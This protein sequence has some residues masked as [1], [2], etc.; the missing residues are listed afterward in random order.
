MTYPTDHLV[1][2]QSDGTVV[3]FTAGG[4][5]VRQMMPD[6]T[7]YSAFDVDGRAHYV[8][9]PPVNGQPA[10]NAHIVYQGGYTIFRYDDRSVLTFDSHSQAVVSLQLPDSTVYS[11]YGPDKR[12]HQVYTPAHDG[13]PATTATITYNNDGTTTYTYTD[14]T[15]ITYDPNNNILTE[16]RPD[17]TTYTNFDT[18]KRPHQIHT[19][20][21]DGKPATTATITYNNDGTT[22]YT[23]TDHTTITYDPNNNIL[24]EQRPDG[25]T[26]TNFDTDK[27]PHQVYTPAHDGKPATTATITYNNDG[28]TTYT[29]TDHTTITYDPN[30]NILTEQRPDGTTYTNFDTDKRPHQ[31]YTPA[32]DGKPATTATIT[33]NNDG[34]TTY[35][36]TDHTT[37]TYDPNNNILTEQ[38]PDG[39]VISFEAGKP[40]SGVNTQTNETVQITPAEGGGTVW[41]YSGGTVVWRDPNGRVTKMA[42]GGWTFTQFDGDSRPIYG[43]NGQQ[44]VSIQYGVNGS[45]T[46]WTYTDNNGKPGITV[47]TNS[48]GVP[49]TQ[50]NPDGSSFEF[51]VEIPKLGEAIKTVARE[52]DTINIMISGIKRQ[53]EALSMDWKSPAGTN[54]AQVVA[55]V[56]KLAVTAHLILSDA[57]TKMVHSYENYV[58]ADATNARNFFNDAN[59]PLSINEFNRPLNINEFNEPLNI[60]RPQ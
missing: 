16:Q 7:T 4:A 24:T 22:T 38:G 41:T 44:S 33:Y 37:I 3:E 20:A 57:V 14:H 15:T 46:K 10:M 60:K 17:G 40:K 53:F 26:Y 55:D 6:G 36:Y 30:N 39:W 49:K 23:Y 21:H 54:F 19:P 48:N 34:T 9:I 8:E 43:T 45:D 29:Y 56:D 35:T 5:P 42:K 28:T 11:N 27:R 58:K 50:I 32:H 51:A 31:V 52:R 2:K 25:T 47:I 59:R 12:P 18:D 1:Q 13:K